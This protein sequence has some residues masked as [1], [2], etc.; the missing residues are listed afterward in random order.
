[1]KSSYIFLTVVFFIFSSC[2]TKKEE[3]SKTEQKQKPNIV[4]ILAD[5]FGLEDMSF[6]G[7]PYYETPHID[8]LASR[9]MVFTQGYAGSR[10]CSPSRATIMTGKFTA[11][12]K[13]MGTQLFLQVNGI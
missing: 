1:M 13:I 10:V 8:K 6:V 5:D 9:S 11:H 2:Q 4:F 12:F 3:D 7:S